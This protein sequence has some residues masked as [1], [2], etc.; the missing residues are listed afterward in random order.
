MGSC[1]T[2]YEAVCEKVQ[3]KEEETDD[4][5]ELSYKEA[6][7]STCV[8]PL[9]VAHKTVCDY[10]LRAVLFWC[11][12]STVTSPNNSNEL[13]KERRA[14][15]T[16]CWLLRR[17]GEH[18]VPT[19]TELIF[20]KPKAIQMKAAIITVIKEKKVLIRQLNIRRFVSLSPRCA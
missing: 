6:L 13:K 14:Y 8:E 16:L 11:T 4:R 17:E 3:W 12:A 19:I 15:S 1:H 9:R 5:D 2:Q 7:G 10:V 18:L 20:S